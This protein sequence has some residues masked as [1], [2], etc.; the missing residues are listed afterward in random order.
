MGGVKKKGGLKRDSERVGREGTKTLDP[1]E[2]FQSKRGGFKR[3]GVNVYVNV[4]VLVCA[5]RGKLATCLGNECGHL[6]AACAEG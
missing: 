5:W 6:E 2:V 3:E 1:K 4:Y